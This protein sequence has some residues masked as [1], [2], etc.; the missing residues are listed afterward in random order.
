MYIFESNGTSWVE[1]Q[2]LLAPGGAAGDLFGYW[3]AISSDTLVV[4]AA[5]Y[6]DGVPNS[7]FGAAFVYT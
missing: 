7:D 2:K 5:L 4:T 3:A 1:H 6:D